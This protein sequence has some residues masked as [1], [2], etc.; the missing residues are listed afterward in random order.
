MVSELKLSL[1]LN[2]LFTVQVLCILLVHFS[3]FNLTLTFCDCIEIYL[4][5]LETWGDLSYISAVEHTGLIRWITRECEICLVLHFMSK[6]CMENCH[7]SG[8]LWYISCWS[9]L[10][11]FNFRRCYKMFLTICM[12][13]SKGEHKAPTSFAYGEKNYGCHYSAYLSSTA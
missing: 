11:C 2:P 12:P 10:D 5:R 3:L 6:A 9:L 7:Q 8:P 4:W 1:L 13:S